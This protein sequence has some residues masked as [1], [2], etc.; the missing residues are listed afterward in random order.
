M[1]SSFLP[2]SSSWAWLPL[3]ATGECFS[4]VLT[5]PWG[6]FCCMQHI[7]C[8]SVMKWKGHISIVICSYHYEYVNSSNASLFT[9]GQLWTKFNFLK[10]VVFSL[11]SDLKHFLLCRVNS[12]PLWILDFFL[13]PVFK[14]LIQLFMFALHHAHAAP[15]QKGCVWL[16][17][18]I[19]RN[20]ENELIRVPKVSLSLDSSFFLFFL[21]KIIAFIIF[22]CRREMR[23]HS[24]SSMWI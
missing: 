19:L 22:H 20:Q 9:A 8:I 7:V 2:Y 14:F 17:V 24:C 5:G 15:L 3:K 13:A 16:G 1:V 11:L 4:L 18:V 23:S 21:Q 6:L 10:A 12:N